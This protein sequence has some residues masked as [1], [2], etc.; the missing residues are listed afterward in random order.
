MIR[1]IRL[2]KYFGLHDIVIVGDCLEE[3]WDKRNAVELEVCRDIVV[4]RV[5]ICEVHE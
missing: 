4:I 3:F 5:K 1:P 2:L